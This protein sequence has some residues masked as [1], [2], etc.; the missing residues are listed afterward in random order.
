M[1]PPRHQRAVD[2]PELV[3][4]RQ[5]EQVDILP[6]QVAR[7]RLITL[8]E[9]QLDALGARAVQAELRGHV[10]AGELDLVFKVGWH[11][12]WGRGRV[13]VSEAQAQRRGQ[14]EALGIGFGSS[15]GLG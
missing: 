14:E 11:L 15:L 3:L 1:E 10:E 12:D 5:V 8:R 9:H 4:V 13:W 7:A 2:A 6:H